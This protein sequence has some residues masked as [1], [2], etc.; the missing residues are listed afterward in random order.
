[1][2]SATFA[3]K[4]ALQYCDII[5]GILFRIAPRPPPAPAPRALFFLHPC[6]DGGVHLIRLDGRRVIWR[7]AGVHNEE[8]V[9]GL[10][11]EG[12]GGTN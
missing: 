7:S 9:P 1:M 6:F 8:Y 5:A 12:G 11:E 2:F 10:H 4:R 3:W